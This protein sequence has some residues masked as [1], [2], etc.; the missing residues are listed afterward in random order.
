MMMTQTVPSDTTIGQIKSFLVQ[1]HRFC[2][3]LTY[4][5]LFR[6]KHP[7]SACNPA[8]HSLVFVWEQAMLKLSDDNQTL[9]SFGPSMSITV[10]VVAA[11]KVQAR[12]AQH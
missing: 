7:H 9:D 4:Q 1:T 6:I 10:N 3:P 8:I 2:R 5:P 12:A 11:S